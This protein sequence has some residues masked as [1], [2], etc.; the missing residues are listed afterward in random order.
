MKDCYSLCHST[1]DGGQAIREE[2]NQPVPEPQ[3]S[4]AEQKME[5]NSSAD[6]ALDQESEEWEKRKEIKVCPILLPAKK[7]T[8]FW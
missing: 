3:G 4:P 5:T 8:C 2:P 1:A 7:Q 6:P